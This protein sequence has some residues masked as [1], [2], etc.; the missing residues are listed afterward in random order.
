MLTNLDSGHARPDSIE[1]VVAGLVDPSLAPE[2][3]QVIADGKPEIAKTLRGFLQKALAGA[4][5]GTYFS[6]DASY[7]ASD[8]ADLRSNLPSAWE[9]SP[10]DLVRRTELKGVITSSY[11]IGRAGDSRLIVI[12][13]DA[14]GKIQGI[15]VFSDPDNR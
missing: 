6:S 11:R 10:F 4:D 5:A 8:A 9:S 13:T 12:R 3:Q 1:R 7:A 15:S 14:A 2:P